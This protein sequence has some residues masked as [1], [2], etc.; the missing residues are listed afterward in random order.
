MG[1]VCFLKPPSCKSQ[2]QRVTHLYST[3]MDANSLHQHGWDHQGCHNHRG[4]PVGVLT[5]S[6][7]RPKKCYGKIWKT[8][9][10]MPKTQNIPNG[11]LER[12]SV[13]WSRGLG[14]V[15]QPRYFLAAELRI[16]IPRTSDLPKVPHLKLDSRT[17]GRTS[18]V[19]RTSPP[20]HASGKPPGLRDVDSM[21]ST[22]KV[23]C[24]WCL[25]RPRI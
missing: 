4:H 7:P 20:V 23:S 9:K 15:K 14:S 8:S 16:Q 3:S 17:K 25:C 5:Y 2:G 19:T 24:C 6:N 21:T 13:S 22:W 10:S 12:A 18:T 11:L 1:H